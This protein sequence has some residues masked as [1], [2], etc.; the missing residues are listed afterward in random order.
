MYG[1]CCNVCL[2]CLWVRLQ[3]NRDSP[4]TQSNLIW[5]YFDQ[6]S[7]IYRKIK[8]KWNRNCSSLFVNVVE[9]VYSSWLLTIIFL[10][11]LC[12]V[13]FIVCLI[14]FV[15]MFFIFNHLVALLPLLILFVAALVFDWYC[16]CD[17]VLYCLSDVVIFFSHFNAL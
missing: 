7:V 15:V 16:C 6:C 14:S 11:H 8:C 10:V 1:V 3:K 9:I 13:V 4:Q 2:V 5:K 12:H 17:S